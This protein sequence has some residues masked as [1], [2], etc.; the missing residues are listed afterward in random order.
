MQAL[1]FLADFVRAIGYTSTHS[2][3]YSIKATANARAAGAKGNNGAVFAATGC[4]LLL[5]SANEL[6][7]V[8]MLAL[9]DAVA[10][11]WMRGPL[12]FNWGPYHTRAAVALLPGV[13][14]PAHKPNVVLRIKV[15]KEATFAKLMAAVSAHSKG[16]F[17]FRRI[18]PVASLASTLPLGEETIK[19][20]VLLWFFLPSDVGRGAAMAT[21]LVKWAADNPKTQLGTAGGAV[22]I[23]MMD[24]HL[25]RDIT[26]VDGVDKSYDSFVSDDAKAVD[27]E[28]GDDARGTIVAYLHGVQDTGVVGRQRQM[29][30][31]VDR[32]LATTRGG[33]L[34]MPGKRPMKAC[35]QYK[36]TGGKFKRAG[37]I[38]LINIPAA[39]LGGRRGPRGGR[40][41]PVWRR[42]RTLPRRQQVFQHTGRGDGAP[43]TL[44]DNQHVRY[45][46]RRCLP[47]VLAARPRGRSLS[48]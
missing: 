1:D 3:P 4:T 41:A 19:T 32:R 8:D 16:P 24:Y 21:A 34:Y 47:P 11:T 22:A 43:G 26:K 37:T 2:A 27:V 5:N 48:A 44:A 14:R 33:G 31:Y 39:D 38:V 18:H 23:A 36:A 10:M 6:R 29:L 40:A 12:V 15:T 25:E 17:V 7:V 45:H 13:E 9:A 35:L 20:D 46:G 28:R 30:A 42:G